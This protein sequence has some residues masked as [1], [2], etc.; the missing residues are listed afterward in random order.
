MLNNENSQHG[1]EEPA[2]VRG[3]GRPKGARN[4]VYRK[5]PVQ[6]PMLGVR[7]PTKELIGLIALV[8][9]REEDSTRVAEILERAMREYV[10]A[11]GYLDRR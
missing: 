7:N 10:E 5:L 1:S 9:L 8:T 4:K 6:N 2:P 11:R 3:R